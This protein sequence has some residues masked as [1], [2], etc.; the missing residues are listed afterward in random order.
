[1][2]RCIRRSLWLPSRWRQ[3]SSLA[4]RAAADAFAEIIAEREEAAEEPV[5][6]ESTANA[7]QILSPKK[8]L[9]KRAPLRSTSL[10]RPFSRSV[11]WTLR[12]LRITRVSK[13]LLS[14]PPS[15]HATYAN[16]LPM[17]PLCTLMTPPMRRPAS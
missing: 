17:I 10:L 5:E 9:L 4:Q 14:L 13:H 16:T 1:M 2:F 15:E 8:L 3:L 11:T 6:A 12:M 7:A